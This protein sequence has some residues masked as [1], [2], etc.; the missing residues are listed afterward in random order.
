MEHTSPGGEQKRPIMF[1]IQPGTRKI[2]TSSFRQIRTSVDRRPY[3]NRAQI[4]QF[5][6]APDGRRANQVAD[7]A[8]MR[9]LAPSPS[10]TL[11]NG[12]LV[13]LLPASCH[14]R[15][16]MMIIRSHWPRPA[17]P[18]A[19]A[20]DARQTASSR[21]DDPPARQSRLICSNSSTRDLAIPDSTPT[22]TTWRSSRVWPETPKPWP[23]RPA[24]GRAQARRHPPGHPAGSAAVHVCLIRLLRFCHGVPPQTALLSVLSQELQLGNYSPRPDGPVRRSSTAFRGRG[25]CRA[26]TVGARQGRLGAS[27]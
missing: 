27:R 4:A 25:G 19:G 1:V 24:A 11:C 2:G 16:A 6:A 8:G 20:H 9:A 7:Q 23:A 18:S 14:G 10:A 21:I 26:P 17:A 5:G 3:R 15:S 13:G 12:H 22:T